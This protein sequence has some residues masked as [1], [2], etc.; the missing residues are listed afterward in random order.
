MARNDGPPDAKWPKLKAPRELWWLGLPGLIL[1]VIGYI[2]VPSHSIR[3]RIAISLALL[4]VPW[5]IWLVLYGYEALLVAARRVIWYPRL[6]NDVTEIGRAL[7]WELEVNRRWLQAAAIEFEIANAAIVGE[8]LQILLTKKRSPTLNEGDL[9]VVVDRLSRV[10][11]GE[12]AVARSAAEGYFARQQR[13]HD[14]LWW[15]YMRQ[16]AEMHAVP[17]TNAVAILIPQGS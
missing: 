4:L 10:R 8:E 5:I 11:L 3:A 2:A 14:G 1:A 7:I 13:I 17:K 6:R 15:G 12:F 9:L 16:Q